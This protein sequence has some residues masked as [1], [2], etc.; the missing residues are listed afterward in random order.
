MFGEGAAAR[1]LNEQLGES[2]FRV[3][4]V[5]RKR[6]DGGVDLKAFGQTMDVKATPRPMVRRADHGH[7]LPLPAR[8]YIFADARNYRVV[9]L[10][11]WIT[12]ERMCE[13]SPACRTPIREA[14]HYNLEPPLE[15]LEQMS[16][17]V[18][19]LKVERRKCR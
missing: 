17:L 2:V 9:R 5:Y 15:E 18:R 12:R 10:L 14:T 8:I 1:W 7:L 19:R 6:G 13:V 4:T 3:D 16:D 11:G